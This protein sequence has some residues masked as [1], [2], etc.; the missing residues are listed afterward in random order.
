VSVARDGDDKR[1]GVGRAEA[2]GLADKGMDAIEVQDGRG[3]AE[4]FR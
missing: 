2:G 1:E 3:V 4:A